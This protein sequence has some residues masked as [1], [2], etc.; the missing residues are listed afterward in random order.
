MI[1]GLIGERLSGKDTV[2]KYLEDK[3][4]AFHIKYSY[5]LDEILDI[6]DQPKSRRNEI[7]IGMAM[8][9]VFHEGVLNSAIKKRILNSQAKLKVINGIRFVDEYETVK[10]LGAKFIYI[11]APQDLLYKRFLVRGQKADDSSL[12]AK[13][14]AALENEPTEIKISQLGE[15]ADFKI[16]N[17]G[18][19]KELYE[20]LVEILKTLGVR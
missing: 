15:K 12:T 8:R 1:I 18:S 9:S 20:K 11:T 19:L 6:L 13:E 17:V 5:I 16:E 2:A 10:A 7:G 4:K 14:F 3:Y